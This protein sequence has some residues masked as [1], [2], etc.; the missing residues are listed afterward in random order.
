MWSATSTPEKTG[1]A[2]DSEWEWDTQNESLEQDGT[3]LCLRQAASCG[4]R[5]FR[6][7]VFP[8]GNL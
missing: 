2:G 4:F 7:P 6:C 1:L 3:G 5:I 8:V